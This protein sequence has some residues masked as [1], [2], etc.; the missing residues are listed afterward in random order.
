MKDFLKLRIKTFKLIKFNIIHITLSDN[1]EYTA[2]ISSFSKVHCYPKNEQEW[3]LA[4][5]GECAIDVEW[6]SGFGI[7]L[8]Q[9]AGLAMKQ[10]RSA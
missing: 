7:H 5:I 2:D 1:S 3:A 4:Y 6:S 10:N 9:I 8:D